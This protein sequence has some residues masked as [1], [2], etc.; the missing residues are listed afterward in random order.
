MK[1]R[2]TIWIKN[3]IDGGRIDPPDEAWNNI[4]Q[5]LDIENSWQKIDKELD[6]DTVWNRLDHQ[7]N[8]AAKM[9]TYEKISYV[10]IVALLLLI[11]WLGLKNEIYDKPINDNQSLAQNVISEDKTDSNETN[12]FKQEKPYNEQTPEIANQNSEKE[13]KNLDKKQE[14]VKYNIKTTQKENVEINEDYKAEI[15]PRN[16]LSKDDIT[17]KLNE[18]YLKYLNSIPAGLNIN[19]DS[20]NRGAPELITFSKDSVIEKTD[21]NIWF[22]GIG[23]SANRTWLNDN[24]LKRASEGSSLYN[25]IASNNLSY[26]INAGL[27]LNQNWAIQSDITL[28]GSI[29]QSYGE[30]INGKYK[31]GKI[32]VNY[33]GL[34]MGL[35]RNLPRLFGEASLLSKQIIA[36]G[37]ANHLYAV[38]QNENIFINNENNQLIISGFYKNWDF[39]IWGGIEMFYTLN[40][41][42][43]L[44][45]ALHY[46]YGLNNIYK[47]D[48]E[49]PA[50]L[51]ETNTSELSLSITLR[52][53]SK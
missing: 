40:D 31:Q 35:K 49:I 45:T 36:G 43:L 30:Y 25:A 10:P 7:L 11:S 52:R 42:Y 19:L 24:R 38:T 16:I 13:H 21:K 26:R 48:N 1:D 3:I 5:K 12:T 15:Q 17:L 2:F 50:Y 14:S 44:G 33:N 20:L 46:K 22:C 47:G 37:Y 51:R 34:Q 41:S 28:L 18:A 23:L 27:N 53:N 8:L 6:I 9:R 29:G 39:G 32:N 4:S